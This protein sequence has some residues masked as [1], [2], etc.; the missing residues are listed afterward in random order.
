MGNESVEENSTNEEKALSRPNWIKIGWQ[1]TFIS[2]EDRIKTATLKRDEN[3]HLQLFLGYL[4]LLT[5]SRDELALAKV[6]CGA[7]GVLNHDAFNVLKKESLQTRMPM[8]Q[9]LI[10][11]Y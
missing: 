7:G 10:K 11:V 4:K 8:Y 1:D 9:V 5:N 2:T 6:L 3:Y